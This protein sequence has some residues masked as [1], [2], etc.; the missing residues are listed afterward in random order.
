MANESI[1]SLALDQDDDA[2]GDMLDALE[3]EFT[4][5]KFGDIEKAR[6]EERDLA[7]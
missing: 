6:K 3:E 5:N 2:I 7:L 1:D 4:M